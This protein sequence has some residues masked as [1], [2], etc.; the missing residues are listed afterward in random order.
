MPKPINGAALAGM[1][2][3][4]TTVPALAQAPERQTLS[5][6]NTMNQ[7][8]HCTLLVDG[9]VRTYLE[10]RPEKTWSE[11]VDPRRLY[12]LVCMRGKEN[13]YRLEPGTRYRVETVGRRVGVAAAD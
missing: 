8:A 6:T 1:I 10:I 3:A 12:Q 2:F 13:A 7:V 5:V 9:R 4:A 11:E